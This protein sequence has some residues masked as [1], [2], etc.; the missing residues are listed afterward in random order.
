M[1]SISSSNFNP[2]FYN[3]LQLNISNFLIYYS[4]ISTTRNV[5]K[6]FTQLQ[7]ALHN[8]LT[9]RSYNKYQMLKIKKKI[10]KQLESKEEI[11]PQIVTDV[12][13]W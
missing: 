5:T 1:H 9:Q 2:Y 12:V 6:L 3:L 8:T 10:T 7:T 13:R 4:T 11:A